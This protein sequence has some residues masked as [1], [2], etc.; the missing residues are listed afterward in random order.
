YT[1]HDKDNPGKDTS[2]VMVVD[3]KTSST[4]D[5]HYFTLSNQSTVDITD[6]NLT[7]DL[8]DGYNDPARLTLSENT[9]YQ[10]PDP[11]PDDINF[12]VSY[13]DGTSAVITPDQ[14]GNTLTFHVT[15][16]KIGRASCRERV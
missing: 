10:D 15:P 11:D 6:A 14:F 9:I 4:T 7:V 5:M 1:A 2:G 16:N 12:I 13:V 8:P 3:D